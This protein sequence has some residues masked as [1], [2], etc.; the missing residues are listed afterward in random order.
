MQTLKMNPAAHK[1]RKNYAGIA[2]A[3]FFQKEFWLM[4]TTLEAW[5]QQGMPQ[6]VPHEELFGFDEPGQYPLHGL[7]WCEAAFCPAFEDRVLEDRGDCELVQDEAGRGV[8][9]F[10]KGRTGYMP[11]YETHPVSD[12]ASW[13]ENCKWRL[14][15]DTPQRWKGFEEKMA[16]AQ[17]AQ[18]EGLFMS[19]RLIGGYMYLRS[20]MGPEGALYIF[21]ENPDLVH[22]C[23]ESWLRLSDAVIAR[24]QEYVTLD[25]IF[26]AE[27]ICFN[28]GPL[29]GPDMMR[30]FLFPYY[31]QLLENAKQR[32]K[33]SN[34][35]LY[36][37]VDTDGDPRMV[38]P[39]YQEIGMDAMSPFE[40]ASGCD[41]VE[42][43]R[44]HPDLFLSGGLDKRVLAK[45]KKAIDEMI[46]RVLPPMQKRGGFIPTIDHGV[47]EEVPYENYLHFRKRCLEF[48]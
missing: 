44:Q 23:M 26:L 10:K 45:D 29:I 8:V 4:S 14:N 37:Q 3:P 2:N 28:N 6:D 9:F 41:V 40:V 19:Q 5:Q 16:A 34:R 47:P 1:W 22:D 25:E 38:I 20:L 11:H 18:Q 35:H 32:H 46:D 39:V 42:I 27:D 21:Y 13:E 48:A 7:G 17:K 30:E 24:H 43:G 36:I 15:P 12:Q 33:A 31:Q